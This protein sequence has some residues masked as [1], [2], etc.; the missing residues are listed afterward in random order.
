MFTPPGW[1]DMTNNVKEESAAASIIPAQTTLRFEQGLADMTAI[2]KTARSLILRR[3]MK[4]GGAAGKPETLPARRAETQR[5]SPD[6]QGFPGLF[7]RSKAK[8]RLLILKGKRQGYL[9]MWR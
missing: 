7:F 5:V 1:F 9:Q 4:A 6:V 3:E 8:Q 2:Q